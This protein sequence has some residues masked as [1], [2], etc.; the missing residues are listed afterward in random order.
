MGCNLREDNVDII[1][2]ELNDK[3]NFIYNYKTIYNYVYPNG[4]LIYSKRMIIFKKPDKYLDV[5]LD[6]GY[7]RIINGKREITYSEEKKEAYVQMIDTVDLNEYFNYN[8]KELLTYWLDNNIEIKIDN[9]ILYGRETYIIHAP[10]SKEEGITSTLWVDKEYATILRIDNY[11]N[12]DLEVSLLFNTTVNQNISDEL[13]EIPS[14]VKVSGWIETG[15]P[16]D[17]QLKTFLTDDDIAIMKSEKSIRDINGECA[18]V[19]NLHSFRFKMIPLE[20]CFRAEYN[21]PAF[22]C[23]ELDGSMHRS[24]VGDADYICKLDNKRIKVGIIESTSPRIIEH[25]TLKNYLLFQPIE[26][27][28]Y[29]GMYIVHR[30]ANFVVWKEGDL[31]IKIV[32]PIIDSENEPLY[33]ISLRN[34]TEEELIQIAQSVE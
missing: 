34:A 30:M 3:W 22:R 24:Y 4:T 7:K 32:S 17:E 6:T 9:D 26:V 23:I 11:E 14:G 16:S 1:A 15:I 2:K 10:F 33:K 25:F 29:K 12:G 28:D 21:K 18:S 20:N 8:F 13:F 5:N 27:K 19:P 31:Y